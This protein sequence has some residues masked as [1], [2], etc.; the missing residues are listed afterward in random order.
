[1]QGL[2]AEVVEGVLVDV[3]GGLEIAQRVFAGGLGEKHDNE[4]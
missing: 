4:M 1:V 2:D 3:E